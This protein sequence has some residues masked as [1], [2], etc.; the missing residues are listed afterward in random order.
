MIL[1]LAVAAPKLMAQNAAG[2]G[3]KLPEAPDSYKVYTEG[4]RLL[5][6]PARLKLLRRER[7]RRSLRWDQFESLWTGAANFPE[8]G[9]AQAMRYRLADDNDAGVR[10]VAWAVGPGDD[11]RQLALIADWCAPLI[12]R[13]DLTQISAKLRREI[14]ET[15]PPRN[16]ADARNR[17]FAAVALTESDAAASEKALKTVIEGFWNTVFIPSLKGPAGNLPNADAYSMLEILHV[18]R[19]NIDFDLRESFPRWFEQYP[20]VHLLSHYPGPWPGSENEFRI[21][22]DD[23]IEKRGPDIRKATLSRAA[24][25]AMVA[26]DA[27]TSSSQ[28]LQGWVTNDRFLMRG[29]LGITYELLW[30]NPYQ[31]GL[32]F[33][34][35]PLALHDEIAGQ[36]FVRSSWDDDASW[37]GFFNG[38]LQLFENGSVTLI[39]PQ[40]ARKPLDVDTAVI[41][42]ARH[43]K[44]FMMPRGKSSPAEPG[45]SSNANVFLVGLDA[46]RAYHLEVDGEEMVESSADP[47]GIIFLPD[48]PGNAGVRL[49][50]LPAPA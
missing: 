28:F 23:T 36:L 45:E 12:S 14:T 24:E 46:G 10:A 1:G 29:T 34:H 17:I 32:S 49:G 9:W 50:D 42:F 48:I 11:I 2:K 44:R 37:V 6:R 16:L 27:N 19:D 47:G 43:E 8:L 40:V 39:D 3:D 35:V 21:P 38:R 33:Q 31:P 13:D 22:A 30:A 4:P 15:R 41:F 20:L 18:V 26:F 7:E 5:L 25:L